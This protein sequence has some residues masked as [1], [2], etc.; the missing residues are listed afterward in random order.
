MSSAAQR[1]MGFIGN[2]KLIL[3]G[4]NLF[5]YL[6]NHDD[7]YKMLRSELF[8]IADNSIEF[9]RHDGTMARI[10]NIGPVVDQLRSNPSFNLEYMG[11]LVQ[12]VILNIGDELSRNGYFDKTPELEFFR[13]LRNG[14]AH[15]NT[16]HFSRN[17]PSRPAAFRGR[18]ISRS[19]DGQ[20]V[21]FGFVLPGD[22]LD[23]IDHLE[24]HL[25]TIP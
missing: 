10:E 22:V 2:A 17:E 11:L 19:L 4:A 6:L 23:L 24:R 12:T 20:Q 21:V 3:V 9:G 13:H 1:A 18:S 8:P 16:F 14:L 5:L 7:H 15:G 25:A